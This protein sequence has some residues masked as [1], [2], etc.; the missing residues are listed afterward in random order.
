MVRQEKITIDPEFKSLIPPHLPAMSVYSQKA[1]CDVSSREKQRLDTI[2]ALSICE[3]CIEQ[4]IG[5][6][7]KQETNGP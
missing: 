5:F 4:A 7:P 3:L 1:I 2:H 6:S